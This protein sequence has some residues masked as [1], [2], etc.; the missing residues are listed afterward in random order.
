MGLPSGVRCVAGAQVVQERDISSKRVLMQSILVGG[1]ITP[2]RF[3]V[4]FLLPKANPIV[5][6][7]KSARIRAAAETKL[8]FTWRGCTTIFTAEDFTKKLNQSERVVRDNP[9][10][11]GVAACRSNANYVWRFDHGACCPCAI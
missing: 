10:G 5:N 8:S 9:G 2:T 11:H 1:A 7:A 4:Q 3:A 6:P